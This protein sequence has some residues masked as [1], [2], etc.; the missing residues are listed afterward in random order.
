MPANIRINPNTISTDRIAVTNAV[1]LLDSTSPQF[2]HITGRART[3]DPVVVSAPYGERQV[4]TLQFLFRV[5][6][7][8]AHRP[9]MQNQMLRLNLELPPQDGDAADPRFAADA[10]HISETPYGHMGF[11]IDTPDHVLRG[12]D[13]TARRF[14]RKLQ[15]VS[16][17]RRWLELL[18]AIDDARLIRKGE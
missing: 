8:L 2:G 11:W 4:D 16:K 5:Y 17:Q 18:R 10:L 9:E 12:Q 3:L 14:I 13:L 6:D 7:R 1:L 15:A